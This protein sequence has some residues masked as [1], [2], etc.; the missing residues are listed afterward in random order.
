MTDEL[1]RSLASLQER[2]RTRRAGQDA[3][4]RAGIEQRLHNLEGDL[5]EV[6]NRINGLI[7]LVAGTVLTQVILKLLH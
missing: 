1:D 3:A 4:F 7:F 6:K 2:Q 5:A